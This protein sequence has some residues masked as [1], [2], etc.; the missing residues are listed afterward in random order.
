LLLGCPH[1]KTRN[2][3]SGQRSATNLI[4][5]NHA[6]K[7]LSNQVVFLLERGLYSGNDSASFRVTPT[8]VSG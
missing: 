1:H 3:R 5:A 6:T 7:A 4:A 2:Y 8:K